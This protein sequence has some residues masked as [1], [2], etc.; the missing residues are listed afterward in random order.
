MSSEYIKGSR[1]PHDP[2]QEQAPSLGWMGLP[3][4]AVGPFLHLQAKMTND[5]TPCYGRK[6]WTSGKAGDKAY[7]IAGCLVC[8]ARPACAEFAQTNNETFG[9]WGG[10]DF[11]RGGT[12]R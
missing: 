1:L 11:S 3:K 10:H 8:H 5:P 4:E 6:E 12:G 9:I 2:G 7:A